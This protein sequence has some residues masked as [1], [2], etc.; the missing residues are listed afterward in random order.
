[1]R[2]PS[3][4]SSDFAFPKNFLEECYK[5][6]GQAAPCLREDPSRHR[7]HERRRAEKAAMSPHEVQQAE[8]LRRAQAEERR[9]RREAAREAAE[10]TAAKES[11]DSGSEGL[12]A[13][14]DEQSEL[15]MQL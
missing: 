6:L 11:D 4:R 5:L 14:L 9:Q 13:V 15:F 12:S 7:E 2:H 10:A 1:M 8:A 3:F